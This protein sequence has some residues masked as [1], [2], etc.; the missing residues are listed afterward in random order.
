MNIILDAC[1]VIAYERGE[2][3]ADVVERYLIEDE[4][5]WIHAINLCEVYYDFLR[6]GGQKAADQVLADL[7]GF[8]VQIYEMVDDTLW[9]VAAKY[10]ATL[11]RISL[12]D[13]FALALTKHLEGQLLTSDHGEFDPVAELNLCPILFIR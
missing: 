1:S 7:K 6:A 2:A 8:D 4:P 11:R 13:C 5:C 12:A 3:G 10:K 9:K